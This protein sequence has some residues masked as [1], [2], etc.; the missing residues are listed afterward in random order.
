M[1]ESFD[2]NTFKAM[3]KT[4]KVE[5]FEPRYFILDK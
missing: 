2:A 3:M 5:G 4:I 1:G